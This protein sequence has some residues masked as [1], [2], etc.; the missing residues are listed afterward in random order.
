MSTRN[1]RW[2]DGRV[3]MRMTF[4]SCTLYKNRAT[5]LYYVRD[6]IIVQMS[7]IHCIYLCHMGYNKTQLKN[8]EL[9]TEKSVQRIMQQLER[10]VLEYVL[11]LHYKW[12]QKGKNLKVI[13]S[14]CT[15]FYVKLA[16]QKK[17]RYGAQ[18]YHWIHVSLLCWNLLAIWLWRGSISSCRQTSTLHMCRAN[19]QQG[20]G[21]NTPPHP[22]ITWKSS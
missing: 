20:N 14:Q 18:S 15:L 13:L 3:C 22:K 1:C 21:F 7:N 11:D 8:Y 16:P 9:R 19:I 10:T 4:S 12:G 5:T 17:G 2:I 6:E